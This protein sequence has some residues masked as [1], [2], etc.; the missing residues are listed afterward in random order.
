MRV[1]I[2]QCAL[3]K[4]A[5]PCRRVADVRRD[6][7]TLVRFTRDICRLPTIRAG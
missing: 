4:T 6:A 5:G 1:Q 3:H 2:N 7:S